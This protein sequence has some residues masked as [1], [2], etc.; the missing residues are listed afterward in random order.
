VY[1]AEKIERIGDLAAHIADTARFTHP[2]RAIPEELGSIFTE[3]GGVAAGMA[4]RVGDF[5]A[6]DA[7]G[8]FVKLNNTDQ[9]GVGVRT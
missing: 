5:I 3:M 9:H 8:G 1:C 2:A 7:E 6:D 4:D